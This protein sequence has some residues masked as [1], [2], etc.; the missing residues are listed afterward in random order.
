MKIIG[1]ALI[2]VAAAATTPAQTSVSGES[3]PDV[4]ILDQKFT[5][6]T[7]RTFHVAPLPDPHPYVTPVNRGQVE[8]SGWG[9]ET[10]RFLYQVKIRN[11]GSKEIRAVEWAYILTDPLSQQVVG[12]HH[13]RSG[14]RIGRNQEKTLKGASANGAV[15]TQVIS[16][17][18]LA[19]GEPQDY[20]EQ[21]IIN[22][23]AYSDGSVWKRPGFR[24]RCEPIKRR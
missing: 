21:V 23:L 13:F 17:D 15:P 22:C 19:N 3:P 24:G 12:R 16:A 10:K 20:G 18:R 6:Q 1:M 8:Q 11:T 4:L 7:V 2:I 5:E 14:E 9:P